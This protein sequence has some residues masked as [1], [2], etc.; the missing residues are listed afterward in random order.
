MKI[1]IGIP[2]YKAQ[3]TI[4]ECLASINIQTMRDDINVIISND[5]P[6]VD[7]YSYLKDKFSKLHITLTETDKNGGPGIARNKAIQVSNDDYIMFM[8]ADDVLYTPY[9]VEQLYN[10]VI[11]QPNIVQCQGIF[12]QECTVNG[13][14]KL[15]PQNNPNHPCSFGRL[16]N[17][18]LLKEAGIDFG[19]LPNME[20]GRFQWCINLFIEGTQ[21][22]RNFI[23]DVVYV[24][25]EGS[26]HSITRG[27]VDINGGIPVYNYSMCQIGASIAAKQA[28]EFAL[29]KNPFNGSIQR[30]LVEQMIGHYFTYYECK[31]KCPKFAEQ[32]WWLSKWFYHNC[33]E[34]YC[35][36]ISDDLLDKFYMQMLSVKGKSLSKFPELTFT[37]WFNKI[38]TEEFVFEELKDIRDKLPKEILDVERKSGSL[39]KEARDNA[40]CI[41]DVDK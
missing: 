21:F 38:K 9:A 25:K 22:K 19:L 28:V 18:K 11:A 10:G 41:F 33:Y 23:N 4:E 3:K 17:L 35:L 8:D 16:T 13:V 24:W 29:N 20:D 1:A 30:F 5:N 40:L 34:K 26:D 27:G 6:G 32:N 36:N 31:E 12:V 14:H 37:Q 2:A 7:D 15:A 39:T